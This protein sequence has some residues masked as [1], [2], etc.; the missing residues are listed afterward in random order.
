M[1]QETRVPPLV[2]MATRA[3]T[4]RRFLLHT[5]R[6][7]G[8]VALATLFNQATFGAETSARGPDF[9]PRAKRVIYLFMSGAPSQMDLFDPKPLLGRMNGQEIPIGS[10][11]LTTMTSG[12]QSFPLAC[13]HFRFQRA[14]DAGLEI[15]ELLPCTATIVDRIAVIRSMYTEPINHDP[16][17]TFVQTG[18][19]LTGRPCL[20][21]WL[22]YGLGSENADLPA[23]IVLTSTG[24]RIGGQP[25]LS[26]YWHSG[27]L[28][29]R[30]Q[31]VQ[32]RSSG[33]AVMGI[34]N[35]SGISTEDRKESILAIN[36]LNRMRLDLVGDPEIEARI[37]SYELAFQM[38]ASVPELM[39]IEDEPQHIL[40]MYGAEPRANTFATNC[41]LARRMVERGVR[42]VQLFDKDWDHH[43]DLPDEL[44]QKAKEVD[45]ASAALICDLEQRGLLNDTIV[46]WGGEFGRTA[47]CQGKL[48]PKTY[49]RDHHPRCFTVWVAGGGIKPGIVLGTT[50]DFSY[51][52]LEDPVHVHDL[53]ATILYCLGINHEK[54]TYRFQGRDFRLTDVSGQVVQPLLA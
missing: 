15:S 33:N 9:S 26:K 32:F 34:A 39:R 37:N 30:H 13:S 25:I 21:S 19:S 42:C 3:L 7:L 53:Q 41:L 46:I 2:E 52:I 12:Q 6:G 20:G 16:A 47:Y 17:I 28:P 31:G 14:G 10:Q 40:D 43:R 23:F 50:D 27:F 49:G 5:S 36:E 24:K 45:Q 4:R 1:M 38:Q 44:R 29:G 22:S 8:T 54:L 11:R 48:T 35:P 51:N 18:S